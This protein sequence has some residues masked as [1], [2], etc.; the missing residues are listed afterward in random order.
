MKQYFVEL[1]KTNLQSSYQ[2]TIRN[3]KLLFKAFK[4]SETLSDLKLVLNR[5]IQILY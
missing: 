2:I 4:A 3:N 1:L 5:E